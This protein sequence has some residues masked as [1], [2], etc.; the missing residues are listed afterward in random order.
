MR[1]FIYFITIGMLLS[2]IVALPVRRKVFQ[3]PASFRLLPQQC[4]G[5]RVYQ[6]NNRADCKKEFTNPTL[7][8]LQAHTLSGYHLPCHVLTGPP[9]TA[10]KCDKDGCDA[11][12]AEPSKLQKHKNSIM[13]H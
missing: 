7:P 8:K 4:D 11:A 2:T 13:M 3:T 10:F 5:R 1:F 9:S 12:F 6:C